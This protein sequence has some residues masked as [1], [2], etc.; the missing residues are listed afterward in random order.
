MGK[1]FWISVVVM[2]ALSLGLSF[3]IHDALLGPDY[4]QQPSLYRP[5][6]EMQAH[7]PVMLLA[8]ALYAFGFTWIYLKGREAAKPFLGQGVRYGLAI[9]VLATIP[10][11][12]IYYVVLPLP[13]ALV[14]KQIVFETIAV[15]IMGVVL[16]AITQDRQRA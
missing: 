3:I 7:F 9:A 5:Q 8:H 12:L 4:A 6:P 14:V 16:A 11:Y 10:T 15:V 2:L 13:A 1:R